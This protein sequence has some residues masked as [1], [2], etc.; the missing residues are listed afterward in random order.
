M[1]IK[2][3]KLLAEMLARYPRVTREE[4]CDGKAIMP[5]GALLHPSAVGFRFTDGSYLFGEAEATGW[6]D[7]ANIDYDSTITE[8]WAH[9]MGLI[10][11]EQRDAI[12]AANRAVHEEREH[13]EY[14]RL[15]AKYEGKDGEAS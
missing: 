12:R 9:K 5:N 10:D 8:E 2:G 6:D 7:E 15:R 13:L 11:E 1:S 3:V 4:D 14:R